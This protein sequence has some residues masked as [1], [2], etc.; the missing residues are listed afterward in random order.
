[1]RA[2][3]KRRTVIAA[4]IAAATVAVAAAPALAAVN[5]LVVTPTP[6]L[7]THHNELHAVAAV[8]AT[9]MFAVGEYYNGTWDH[10]LILKGNGTTW[11]ASS[12][13]QPTF[14]THNVLNG[15][16]MANASLGWA[17]GTYS[18]GKS[19]YNLVE[20]YSGGSW[21]W[22]RQSNPA[23]TT[24]S[25][26]NGVAAGSA[27]S[28]VA[29]GDSHGSKQAPKP[30]SAFFNGTSWKYVAVPN[31]GKVG[32]KAHTAALS[33]VA[34]VPGTSGK[35]YWAV[36]TYSNGFN[37]FPFFDYWNGKKWSQ[38]VLAKSVQSV[39]AAPSP[40]S[41]VVTSV[42]VVSANNAWA[43]G[44]YTANHT[45]PVPSNNRTF[46]VHWNGVAWSMVKSPNRVSD[47][48]PN[49]LVSVSARGAKAIYAVGRYFAGPYDQ[50]QA[51]VWNTTVSPNAWTKI[52][53]DNNTTQHNSLEGI[54]MIPV[55]GA[56]SVG[57]YY[58]GTADRTLVATCK[59]C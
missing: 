50:T 15:V 25:E 9:E 23:G 17:V 40:V 56:V 26:F 59:D 34:V 13:P 2:L 58:S 10:G 51:L 45:P 39:I 22:V 35:R 47:S 48:T 27:R 37:T 43:V 1:M 7:G 33:S 5:F 3:T 54:A 52:T 36:G 8:S 30:I 41:S 14:A 57:T 19:S 28:V 12:A 20:R 44:Y 29:V 46:T 21:S 53:S 42:A 24:A 16:A 11:A 31:P 38:H 32:T 18:I 49:E 4:G 55:K 6:N